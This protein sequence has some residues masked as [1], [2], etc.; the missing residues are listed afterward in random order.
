MPID[1][2]ERS[3]R[4]RG[5]RK[6][7]SGYRADLSRM[8]LQHSRAGERAREETA[9]PWNEDASVT[10]KHTGELWTRHLVV[11]AAIIGRDVMSVKEQS[12]LYCDGS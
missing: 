7:P 9:A 1:H 6:G 10:C 2:S 8:A 3:G 11:D 12:F 5:H 4:E